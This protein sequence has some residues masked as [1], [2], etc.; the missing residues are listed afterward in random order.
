MYKAIKEIGE[1]GI[2]DIVP[3]RLAE[4]WLQMYSVPH[5]E[6][7][8]EVKEVSEPKKEKVVE[9]NVGNILVDYL[10]RNQSV[11]KK[12]VMTD[13]LNKYQLEEL[14]KLE[15]SDKNR[16]LVLNTIKQRLRYIK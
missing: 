7:V 9:T 16:P 11:V 4:D 15:E 2:G 1:Y 8:K 3:D 13:K 5:V 6:E 12:N 14:L 10:D